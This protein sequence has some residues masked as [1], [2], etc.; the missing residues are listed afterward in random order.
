[1]KFVADQFVHNRL[2]LTIHFAKFQTTFAPVRIVR[3]V[4]LGRSMIVLGLSLCRHLL[5]SLCDQLL[6]G[7]HTAIRIL[8]IELHSNFAFEQSDTGRLPADLS[9]THVVFAAING[10]IRFPVEFRVHVVL[11]AQKEHLP[12]QIG[13][14]QAMNSLSHS[15]IVALADGRCGFSGEPP[16]KRVDSRP[17]WRGGWNFK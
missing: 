13:S 16:L 5:P 12:P 1:M 2:R 17:S 9:S 14:T 15:S 3:I 11:S 7:I 10:E 6:D 8:F 4:D